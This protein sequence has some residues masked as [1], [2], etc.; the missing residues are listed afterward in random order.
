MTRITTILNAVRKLDILCYNKTRLAGIAV[1][2]V[3]AIALFR[4][5]LM[6]AVPAFLSERARRKKIAPLVNE[7]KLL[8][9][10][11]ESVLS[12]PYQTVGKPV[13]W[14]I[15]NRGQGKITY[16]GDENKHII[17]SPDADM[18]LFYGSK[19]SACTDMLLIIQGVRAD[20]VVSGSTSISI[21]VEYV[22]DAPL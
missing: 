14:C 8:K 9:I 2:V 13:L 18:P 17:P 19:H 6:P 22:C 1:M 11:Y 20:S 15:Q 5:W 7:A 10:S 21:E 12:Y 16:E 4:L 3:C